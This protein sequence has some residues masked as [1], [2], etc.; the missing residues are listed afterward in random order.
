MTATES[1][2]SDRVWTVP[3]ALSGLRLLGVP[4]FLYLVLVAEA[5]GWA[6]LLLIGAGI[7]DY[8]DGKIARRFHQHSKLG[9]VLD[10]AADRLYILATL[11]AL[12]ARD[13]LP[14]WWALALIA[15]DL[16][17]AATL[18]VLR[19]HGYGPLQVSYLGKAATFNLLYAFPMLLAALPGNDDLLATVV[20]PLGWA[21][22]SWGSVLYLVAGVAYLVQVRRLVIAD[23]ATPPW[24]AGRRD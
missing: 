1:A 5:D 18:P 19:K 6:V 4:L 10:P 13:G 21:F 24:Q 3:N 2:P 11:L 15:R 14:L 7:T 8:L 9:Q 16:V 12:V 20:R 17:L 23:R 22:A